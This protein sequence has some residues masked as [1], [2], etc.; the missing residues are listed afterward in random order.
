[1]KELDI[2]CTNVGV[3]IYFCTALLN[4]LQKLKITFPPPPPLSFQL[5]ATTTECGGLVWG[6]GTSNC[7]IQFYFPCLNEVSSFLFHFGSKGEMNI[8]FINITWWCLVQDCLWHQGKWNA[9]GEKIWKRSVQGKH[10]RD[11]GYEHSL[12]EV[13]E[14]RNRLFPSVTLYSF[15]FYQRAGAGSGLGWQLIGKILILWQS[16]EANKCLYI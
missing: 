3:W 10:F 12:L 7:C 14:E 15:G 6:F 9:G 11:H 13:T 4:T 5:Y 8:I 16:G 1:M 2:F